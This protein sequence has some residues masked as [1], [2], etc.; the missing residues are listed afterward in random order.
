MTGRA[1][2]VANQL[3][4]LVRAK[5]AAAS[6]VI[7]GAVGG[8][9]G[10]ALAMRRSRKG[11]ALGGHAA[12]VAERARKG[13]RPFGRAAE[14]GELIPLALKLLENPIVRGLIVQAVTRSLS[15][16]FR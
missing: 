13:G 9:I 2:E 10:V 3:A 1:A 11:K 5:P 12:G 8:A 6:A 15:K 14:Y 16:R 7:A 4:E